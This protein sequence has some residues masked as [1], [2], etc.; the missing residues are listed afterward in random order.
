MKGH[1]QVC[2][3][4]EWL[5]G[6]HGFLHLGLMDCVKSRQGREAMEDHENINRDGPLR[7]QS[8]S[9]IHAKKFHST[10]RQCQHL[11]FGQRDKEFSTDNKALDIRHGCPLFK[12]QPLTG[13]TGSL[14]AMLAGAGTLCSALGGQVWRLCFW[15]VPAAD[16]LHLVLPKRGHWTHRQQDLPGEG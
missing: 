7:M 9:S 2:W 1:S 4:H 13:D 16:F 5:C 3:L 8:I 15:R 11:L 14:V 12:C 10:R 6:K